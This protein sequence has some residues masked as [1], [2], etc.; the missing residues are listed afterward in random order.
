[1]NLETITLGSFGNP[2]MKFVGI[3]VNTIPLKSFG[4]VT[5]KM[6]LGIAWRGTLV[7]RRNMFWSPLVVTLQL[8]SMTSVHGHCWPLRT[9][10]PRA[11]PVVVW[12]NSQPWRRRCP[13]RSLLCLRKCL[14]LQLL[15]PLRRL[16]LLGQNEKLRR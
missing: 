6:N 13:S 7:D 12:S 14:G 4:I 5:L 15:L 1:M 11:A 3:T 10:A 2:Q 9:T 8:K 16:L